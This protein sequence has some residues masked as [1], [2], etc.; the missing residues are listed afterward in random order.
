MYHVVL[1]TPIVTNRTINPPNRQ[2]QQFVDY[3][4]VI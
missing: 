1:I 2:G 3:A 4:Y